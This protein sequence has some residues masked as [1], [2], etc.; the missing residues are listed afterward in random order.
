MAFLSTPRLR[1]FRTAATIPIALP[2]APPLA[3]HAPPRRFHRRARPA[4]GIPS[5]LKVLASPSAARHIPKR[6]HILPDWI[7]SRYKLHDKQINLPNE[8]GFT[9]GRYTLPC[10]KPYNS[11]MSEVFES[12]ISH[13]H[14]QGYNAISEYIRHDGPWL[15]FNR[16]PGNVGLIDPLDV[17]PFE[18][19]VA[20]CGVEEVGDCAVDHDRRRRSGDGRRGY[21]K[22]IRSCVLSKSGSATYPKTC[23]ISRTVHLVHCGLACILLG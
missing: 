12:P 3:G 18:G 8:V 22:I 20:A 6:E 23:V 15:I 17:R 13:L 1:I 7:L 5:R 2:L 14:S 4:T 9:Y 10:C 16:N 21:G 19:D 11:R